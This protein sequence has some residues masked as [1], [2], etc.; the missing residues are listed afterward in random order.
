MMRKSNY[1]CL[2]QKIRI[3]TNFYVFELLSDFCQRK[4]FTQIFLPSL[5][6]EPFEDFKLS[7]ILNFRFHL[8][9]KFSSFLRISFSV[10]NKIKRNYD[11][12]IIIGKFP[13]IICKEVI[14]KRLNDRKN[15]SL[16]IC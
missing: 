11:S 7:F 12:C 14:L 8:Q 9:I 13:F 4:T 6:L 15:F 5:F 3:L 10:T 16:I 2:Y 1:S